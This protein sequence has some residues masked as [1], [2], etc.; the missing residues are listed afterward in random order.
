MK[1]NTDNLRITSSAS[2]MAPNELIDKY[3][4]S[5]IGSTGVYRSREVIK[6]ILKGKDDRLMV[7]VGPCSIHD[8]AAAREY[9]EKLSLVREELKN[10]LFIV[11]RVQ[12]LDGRD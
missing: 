5:E 10:E 1:Y 12:L 8:P 3:P 6:N 11:M 7:I 9:A 4:L 2:I